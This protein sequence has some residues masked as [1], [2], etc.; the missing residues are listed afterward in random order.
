MAFEESGESSTW[1]ATQRARATNLRLNQWLTA[2]WLVILL[3]S[4]GYVLMQTS[5][6]IPQLLHLN[7]GY[8]LLAVLIGSAGLFVAILLW[9]RILAAYGIH[10]PLRDDIRIYC[11]SALGTAIPGGIW[12]VVGRTVLY[13]RLDASRVQVAVASVVETLLIGI[14]AL[15]LYALS[16]LLKPELSVWQSAPLTFA[17]VALPFVLLHPRVF[18][19]VVAWTLRLSKRADSIRP[20]QFGFLD[21]TYWV[22]A[23]AVV[24]LIGGVALYTLLLS[25]TPVTEDVIWRVIAGW[26]AA[27]A[28]SNLFF[29]LPGTPIVRDS[30]L[31]L[32]LNASLPLPIVL[33]FV[34]LVR[35]WSLVSLLGI[36]LVVWV[37]LDRR[38]LFSGVT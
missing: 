33:I 37:A 35:V 20:M 3:G 22:A 38:S 14:A 24:L 12:S 26:A 7:V 4:I 2:A 15:G 5:A 31:I 18:N 25:I 11:Y 34:V 16:V 13:G 28:V 21:L 6:A 30:A 29:W 10:R 23:E 32:L 19:Q 36:A 1:F 9:R 17:F 27:S 8:V